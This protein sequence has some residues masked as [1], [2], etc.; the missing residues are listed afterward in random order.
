MTLSG[1]DY[2]LNE[3]ISRLQGKRLG[4]VS[5][6]SG[7]TKTLIGNVEALQQKQGIEIVALFG[8]EHGFYSAEADGL[9]VA[10][11]K[12]Q[13]TGLPIY[14][15]YGQNKQPTAV[16]LQESNIE[17]FL[18]DIQ[19]VGVRFY[20]YVATL[21]NIMQTAAQYEL[22]VFVCD[23]PNPIGGQIVEG[24]VLEAGLES[25]VGPGPLPIRH[26][27][28]IAELARLFQQE[29]DVDCDLQL[30]PC[31]GWQREFWF[32][33]TDLPWVQPSPGMPKLETAIVY[34]GMCLFEGTNVSEG[35]G[36]TLP[37]EQIGAPWLDAWA[38]A[39]RLNGLNLDGVKFRPCHFTPAEYKW[40]NQACGG[41][42][43][44]VLDRHSFRPVTVALH[45]IS[46]IRAMYPADFAWRLPHFEHLMGNKQVIPQIEQGLSVKEIMATWQASLAQFEHQRE[47]VLMYT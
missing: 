2:L 19:A 41:I 38:V 9:A 10:S 5:G 32:D 8:P 1:L 39:D 34:P 23:R 13:R 45:L 15:L 27:L 29:W 43:V 44:H 4:L 21:L 28:T 46:E 17:A 47:K 33:Q 37:F 36:T 14:S 30:I 31:Q 11:S 20:T 42:Q 3:D 12:D 16:M 26:G 18:F 40:Q 35:R 7:V 22:S 24:P 25:F 6:A